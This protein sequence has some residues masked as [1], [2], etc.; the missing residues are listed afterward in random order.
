MRVC[1]CLKASD[2]CL[3]KAYSHCEYSENS[4]RPRTFQTAPIG[5][6]IFIATYFVIGKGVDQP[7]E[8]M[9]LPAHVSS[10]YF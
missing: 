4:Y 1:V 7:L 8:G 2:G 9:L 5:A 6:S 3:G 10:I